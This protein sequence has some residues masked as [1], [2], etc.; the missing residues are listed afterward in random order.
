MLTMPKRLALALAAGSISYFAYPQPNFWPAIFV[1]VAG[2]L[3]SI[4]GLGVLKA[5]GVSLVGGAAFYASQI[6]RKS[7]V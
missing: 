1:S 5:F 2:L 3:V 4:R 6:D 7:V